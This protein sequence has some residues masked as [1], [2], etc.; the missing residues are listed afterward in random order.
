[1]PT[2]TAPWGVGGWSHFN[3]DLPPCRSN[4]CVVDPS[5][6]RA[7]FGRDPAVASLAAGHDRGVK[8]PKWRDMRF[9]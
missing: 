7:G 4:L 2:T 1:M 5:G 6:I 9:A 8:W 3:E